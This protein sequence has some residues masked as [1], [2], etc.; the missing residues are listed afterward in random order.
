MK[1]DNHKQTRENGYYLIRLITLIALS[2]IFLAA[3]F[4]LSTSIKALRNL[5]HK[6]NHLE[7]LRK[8]NIQERIPD[9]SPE[10][11]CQENTITEN[12][13]INT[14]PIKMHKPQLYSFIHENTN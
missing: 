6:Q 3:M 8:Q 9:I 7:A 14:C 4:S 13:K 10:T 5:Y 11:Q 2:N 12:I 1:T